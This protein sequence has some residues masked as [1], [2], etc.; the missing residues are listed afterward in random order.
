MQAHARF[1]ALA[2]GALAAKRWLEGRALTPELD[3]AFARAVAS[4]DLPDAED[5]RHW[6]AQ[7]ARIAKP[8]RGRVMDL[9]YARLA[10]ELDIDVMSARAAVLPPRSTSRRR[11]P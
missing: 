5:A 11:R 6:A 4:S 7:L 1:H 9:V 2:R 8:P 3:A 10:E